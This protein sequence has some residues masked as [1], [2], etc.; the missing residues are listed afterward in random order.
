MG[1]MMADERDVSEIE[2]WSPFTRLNDMDARLRD[3]AFLL[4]AL[5]DMESLSASLRGFGT[6]SA[7]EV[8]NVVLAAIVCQKMWSCDEA[9]LEAWRQS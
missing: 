8:F 9:A 5:S 4:K 1:T 3:G 6:L 7:R 2:T